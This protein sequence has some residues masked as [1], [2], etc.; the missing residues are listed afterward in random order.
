MDSV[1]GNKSDKPPATAGVMTTDKDGTFSFDVLGG[2]NPSYK[3]KAEKDGFT[4][5]ESD[6]ASGQ[7]A[8]MCMQPAK[9]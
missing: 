6:V 4:A 9:K 5:A 3:V 7:P 8:S 2:S 1:T